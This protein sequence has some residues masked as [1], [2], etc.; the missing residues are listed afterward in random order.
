VDFTPAPALSNFTF[1]HGDQF[2]GWE[3]HLLV[4]SL[5]ARTLYRLRIRDGR[6]VEQEK[7]LNQFGRIRDVEMGYDGLV[8]VL[9]EHTGGGSLV[10]LRP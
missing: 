1:H 9:L 7:L 10:R 8:Y 2:P 4:G 6:L 3:D 5:R